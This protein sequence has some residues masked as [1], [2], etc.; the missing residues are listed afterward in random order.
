[1]HGCQVPGTLFSIPLTPLDQRWEDRE[2]ARRL[3]LLAANEG[4]AERYEAATYPPLREALKTLFTKRV[5]IAPELRARFRARL[6]CLRNQ[7]VADLI[8][9]LQREQGQSPNT[10]GAGA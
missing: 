5:G 7:T 6:H 4:V 10:S 9:I 3:R 2:I 1:M 8:A